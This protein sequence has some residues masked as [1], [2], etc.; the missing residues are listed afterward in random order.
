MLAVLG[1]KP[2]KIEAKIGEEM[3]L[4]P[5]ENGQEERMSMG[6]RGRMEA[7]SS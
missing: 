4:L 2:K 1:I 6:R 3:K 7:Q 5:S